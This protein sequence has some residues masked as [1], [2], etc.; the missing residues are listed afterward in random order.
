MSTPQTEK[1][2]PETV[3]ELT[4]TLDKVMNKTIAAIDTVNDQIRV[5]ALNARIEAARAGDAG[6][7]FN[8]VAMEIAG[9]SNS[10]ARVVANLKQRSGKTL[11]RIGKVSAQMTT[12]FK[13]TRLSDLA[14]MNIDLIDRN[15]YERSC[16]VRWWATD[17]SLVNALTQRTPEAYNFASQR[18]GVILDSYTVYYDLVLCDLS[19]QII[20]NGR[21]DQYRSQGTEHASSPWFQAALATRSGREFGFQSVHRSA[22]V[23]NRLSLVYSCV[24]RE[25]GDVNGRPLGVLGIVFN[26]ESLAQAIVNGV[27]L[28]ADEK[29]R[30][31]VCIVDDSGRVLADSA[32]RVL[33]DV[34]DFADR[35]QL[36]A[37]KKDYTVSTV[38]NKAC[39]IAHALSPGY[40]TYATGWHSLII[41]EVRASS[42]AGR[43][44][45][46]AKKK[47]RR[48]RELARS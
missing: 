20:A 12:A 2:N 36:F 43:R 45:L 1:F 6:K 41:Q 25:G 18:M 19:G 37:R 28:D 24:V 17:A 22:A 42:S 39:C 10:S 3:A 4:S 33:D 13:G 9:L 15:L 35:S 26:W 31:R 21:P 29:R 40:E 27:S 14:L 44:S 8:I 38:G 34:I 46:A 30:S 16:D 23:N 5:L 11:A 48:Q 7:A 32:G 47:K